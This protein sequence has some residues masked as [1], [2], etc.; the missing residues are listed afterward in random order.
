MFL[1]C[2][3]HGRDRVARVVNCFLYNI[4]PFKELVRNQLTL[5]SLQMR[6]YARN[7]VIN[8]VRRPVA[9]TRQVNCL[10][11]ANDLLYESLLDSCHLT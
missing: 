9:D 10:D 3:E 8:R 6:E 11:R 5:V 2:G 4:L 7:G 1:D